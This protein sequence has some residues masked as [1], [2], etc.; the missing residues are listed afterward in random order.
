[1]GHDDKDTTYWGAYRNQTSTVDF[2]ALRHNLDVVDFSQMSSIFLAKSE[3]APTCVSEKGIIEISRDVELIKLLEREC[4]VIDQGIREFGSLAPARAQGSSTVSKYAA[5]RRQYQE[6]ERALLSK[7][8]EEGY[9]Q[10]FDNPNNA[11]QVTAPVELKNQSTHFDNMLDAED[12]EFALIDPAL[13]QDIDD[14]AEDLGNILVN[15]DSH[16]DD[17]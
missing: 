13:L 15:D 2:Q 6:R 10:H 4:E 9:R 7:K 8:F 5:I 14:V 12:A 3:S 11:T 16:S 1:M 17:T